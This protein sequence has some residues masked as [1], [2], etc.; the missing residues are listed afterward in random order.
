MQ[1]NMCSFAGNGEFSATC[2]QCGS[3]LVTADVSQGFP[4]DASKRKLGLQKSDPDD[5]Y[6]ASKVAA[7]SLP[8]QVNRTEVAAAE[9]EVPSSDTEGAEEV[10]DVRNM[11][12]M[13]MQQSERMVSMMTTVQDEV[14][15]SKQQTIDALDEFKT[16]VKKDIGR[17]DSNIVNLTSEHEDTKANIASLRSEFDL[18]KSTIG[19][20]GDG[21]GKGKTGKDGGG[22]GDGKTGKEVQR[23]DERK[24]T[25]VFSNFPNDTQEDEIIKMIND[26]VQSARADVEDV[27]AFAKSG[28]QG[29]AKFKTDEAMWE[30]LVAKKGNHRHYYGGQRIYIQAGGKGPKEEADKDKAVRKVVRMLIESE[31]AAGE[32]TKERIQAKYQ[33]GAVW[34]RLKVAQWNATDQKMMLTGLAHPLQAAYDKFME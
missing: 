31:T 22:K 2:L 28:T 6:P 27:Y 4:A 26:K 30:Y 13:I 19:G 15:S 5:A 16:D 23:L 32:K 34:L 1:S 8:S 25:V 21:K 12:K 14:K 17:L 11:F 29:A 24:R 33:L 3:S 18:F 20:K 7:S 9:V 10:K